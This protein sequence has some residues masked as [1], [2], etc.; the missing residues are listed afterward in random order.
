MKI[1]R[2]YAY[3]SCEIMA[4]HRVNDLS[5][6]PRQAMPLPRSDLQLPVAVVLS[7]VAVMAVAVT[8]ACEHGWV[9]LSAPVLSPYRAWINIGAQEVRALHWGSACWCCCAASLREIRPPR[10]QT[11]DSRLT[12][13]PR[14]IDIRWTPLPSRPKA[15]HQLPPPRHFEHHFA[16]WI[17]TSAASLFGGSHTFTVYTLVFSK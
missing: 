9:S 11:P 1:L 7:A 3:G 10:L 15:H 13:H 4:V 14:R 5:E 6:D 16:L 17:A 2:P 12:S 8:A